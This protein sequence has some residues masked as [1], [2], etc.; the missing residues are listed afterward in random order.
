MLFEPGRNKPHKCMTRFLVPEGIVN[1]KVGKSEGSLVRTLCGYQV[2]QHD[3]GNR[4]LT[5][6]AGGRSPG[7]DTIRSLTERLS[8]VKLRCMPSFLLSPFDWA[9]LAFTPSLPSP[10]ARLDCRR[11]G[12][13]TG[14]DAAGV[15]PFGRVRTCLPPAVDLS[16]CWPA[17]AT[18]PPV[19]CLAV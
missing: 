3:D 6:T 1:F 9:R 16:P 11:A 8:E 18:L 15:G 12:G 10:M 17:R 19:G 14:T 2:R 5:I 4:L 7:E 13:H